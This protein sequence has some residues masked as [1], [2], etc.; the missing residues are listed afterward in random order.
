VELIREAMQGMGQLRKLKN[1][2]VI[3]VDTPL[4]DFELNHRVS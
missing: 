2:L 4:E 3:E 1:K